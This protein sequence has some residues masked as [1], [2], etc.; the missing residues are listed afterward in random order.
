MS[1]AKKLWEENADLSQ[2]ALGHRF[3]RGLKDGTLPLGSFKE[4]IGQ[5]AFFLEAFARAYALALA[6]GPDQ[7]SLHEFAE[8]LSG[9]LEELKMHEGY[10]AQWEVRLKDVSPGEATLAYTDFLLSTAALGSVGETCA[11][12]TPCM[13]LYA[14]LGQELAKERSGEDNPYA[15]WIQTYSDPEFEALADRLEGLLDR[16]AADTPAVRAAYRRA[17]ALEVA[18]FEANAETP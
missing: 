18:F 12:M 1:L 6:H 15:E 7:E 5:D 4:Y 9:V 14:F 17:M 2:R 11:V 10:A 8:L 3:V 13:R 16:Y